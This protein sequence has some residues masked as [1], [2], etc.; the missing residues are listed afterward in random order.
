MALE[1]RLPEAVLNVLGDRKELWCIAKIRDDRVDLYECRDPQRK[2]E[3]YLMIVDPF[4][5]IKGSRSP[6]YRRGFR[7][8]SRCETAYL[9]DLLYCP[10]CGSQLR[11][12]PRKN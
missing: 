3:E 1:V 10:V 9:T 7:Y 8:Y 5:E 6:N 12:K 11:T 4:R 2:I